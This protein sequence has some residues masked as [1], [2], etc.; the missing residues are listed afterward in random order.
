MLHINRL[1]KLLLLTMIKNYLSKPKATIKNLLVYVK[2]FCNCR[3]PNQCY[4]LNARLNDQS[5]CAI[6]CFLVRKYLQ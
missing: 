6:K 5:A 1:Q 4:D 3:Y 2:R